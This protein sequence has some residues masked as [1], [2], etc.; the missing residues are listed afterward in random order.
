MWLNVTDFFFSCWFYS[1]IVF[2]LMSFQCLEKL[3]SWKCFQLVYILLFICHDVI[4]KYEYSFVCILLSFMVFKMRLHLVSNQN[5][6]CQFHCPYVWLYKSYPVFFHL[7]KY[8]VLWLQRKTLSRRHIQ[9]RDVGFNIKAIFWGPRKA[10]ERT[11][12]ELSLGDF[13]LTDFGIEVGTSNISGV[14]KSWC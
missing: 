8:L 5:S 14:N 2:G 13:F 9:N 3:L 6:I 1:L 4:R 10:V 11:K 7:S 12:Q